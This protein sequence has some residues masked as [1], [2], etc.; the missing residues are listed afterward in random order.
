MGDLF[1]MY[2]CNTAII[3]GQHCNNLAIASLETS[4]LISALL[5]AQT[6]AQLDSNLAL[7]DTIPE[8]NTMG[9]YGEEMD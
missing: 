1:W 3:H 7:P 6:V 8:D 2:L 5:A 4:N 9:Q